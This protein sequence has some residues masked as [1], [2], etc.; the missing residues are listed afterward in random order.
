M[1]QYRP[2][3]I[4]PIPSFG[5]VIFYTTF[6]FTS[7]LRLIPEPHWCCDRCAKGLSLSAYGQVVTANTREWWI[8]RLKELRLFSASPTCQPWCRNSYLRCRGLPSRL[9]TTIHD[10]HLHLAAVSQGS[11]TGS[12]SSASSIAMSSLAVGGWVDDKSRPC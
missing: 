4:V 9:W 3:S 12:T 10:P 6:I 5:S 7:S 8:L 2:L 1:Q 11:Q